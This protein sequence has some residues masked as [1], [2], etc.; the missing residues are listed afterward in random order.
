MRE[1]APRQALVDLVKRCLTDTGFGWEAA[2]EAGETFPW[3]R[4]PL[5]TS[6]RLA[7]VPLQPHIAVPVAL[8]ADDLVNVYEEFVY[9]AITRRELMSRDIPGW[10]T[11]RLRST[12]KAMQ[13]LFVPPDERYLRLGFHLNLVQFAALVAYNQDAYVEEGPDTFITTVRGQGYR[14]GIEGGRL[15]ANF[16]GNQSRRRVR[17]LQSSRRLSEIARGLPT[18]APGPTLFDK[19]A[20]YLDRNESRIGLEFGPLDLALRTLWWRTGGDVPAA[21]ID[22]TFRESSK[23]ALR[24]A[25]KEARQYMHFVDP[26]KSLAE[27]FVPQ[28][29]TLRRFTK[30]FGNPFQTAVSPTPFM[31]RRWEAALSELDPG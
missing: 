25:V 2:R 3:S 1:I 6:S 18:F 29:M 20:G 11:G 19:A 22:L 7:G 10:F 15:I 9:H 31:Q 21:L 13:L 8:D 26:M 12:T 17:Q 16:K 28:F 4:P 23:D 14:F 24:A 5:L 27:I 30:L